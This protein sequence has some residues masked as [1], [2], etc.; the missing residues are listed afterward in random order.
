MAK[1]P[2]R[3]HLSDTYR[4]TGFR[5]LEQIKGVFGDPRARV[6]TLLRRSKKRRA[7]RVGDCTSVGTTE[8]SEEFAICRAVTAACTWNSRFGACCV[9]AAAK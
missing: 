8:S 5:A 7:V 4:F 2:T 6:V 1:S 9:E 3:R